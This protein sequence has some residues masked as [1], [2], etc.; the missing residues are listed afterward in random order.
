MSP[1][2]YCELTGANHTHGG[3]QV[4]DPYR[5]FGP[6]RSTVIIALRLFLG[7]KKIIRMKYNS[8]LHT[9]VKWGLSV[10]ITTTHANRKC[11]RFFDLPPLGTCP[12]WRWSS[13]WCSHWLPCIWLPAIHLALTQSWGQRK[14]VTTRPHCAHRPTHCY[15]KHRG[16]CET[17]KQWNSTFYKLARGVVYVRS[18]LPRWQSE[19]ALHALNVQL[20]LVGLLTRFANL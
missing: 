8:F 7:L 17:A 4:R 15:D 6:Q 14:S 1:P 3:P 9:Q 10:L 12:R 19:G 20:I 18:F 13:S 5:G 16:T 2:R 11:V